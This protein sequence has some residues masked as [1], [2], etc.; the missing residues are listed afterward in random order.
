MSTNLKRFGGFYHLHSESRVKEAAKTADVGVGGL[1]E[2]LV[3]GMDDKQ[4]REAADRGRKARDN[5]PDGRAGNG[6]RGALIG[7]L[8]GMKSVDL[9]KLIAE[10]QAKDGTP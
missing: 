7:K 3:L 6:T 8:M 4:L 9:E 2:L 5:Y 1:L 10:A